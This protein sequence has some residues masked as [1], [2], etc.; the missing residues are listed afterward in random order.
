[1]AEL[2]LNR[3]EMPRQDPLVRAKNFLEVA[4]GYSEAEALAEA[5]RCIQCPKRPCMNGCPV[6]VDIPDFIKALR[7]GDMTG[8]ARILKSKNKLPCICGRVCPQETQCEE[9]C[10]LSRRGAPVAIGRLERYV[11]DWEHRQITKELP[12]KLP[13]TGKR[14]AVVGSGPAGL[15]CAADLAVAG[16]E[17][18]IFEALHVPGG[19]LIYGIPEFRLPNTIVQQEVDFIQ[20]LGVEVRLDWVIG[21]TLAVDELFTQGYSA[22]FLGTGAGLPMFLNVPGESFD[23]IYSANEF[24]T[25]INLMH[26]GDPHYDTPLSM[27]S[28]VAVIGGGNVAMD[29]ARCALRAGAGQ[30]SIVYRRTKEEAPARAEEL[31]NACEEGIS[32]RALTNPVRF[33]ATARGWVSA[34]ECIEMELGEPDAKGRRRPVP[35]PNSNFIMSVDTVVIALGTTPNPLVPATTPGLAT[36]PEGTLVVDKDGRTTKSGVWAGGDAATGAATVISAMGAGRTAAVSI[37][38]YLKSPGVWTGPSV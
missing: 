34:M 10:V 8:A 24:L 15:T 19:V 37:N 18:T 3:I 4:L 1:M 27:G 14:V 2:N 13:S 22:V 16:H 6:G 23:G 38:D 31:E 20:A 21:N 30:V 17:V 12:S 5:A 7:E 33:L 25:R 36:H 9:L 29:A 26:A 11:A 35:K 28:H 32:F